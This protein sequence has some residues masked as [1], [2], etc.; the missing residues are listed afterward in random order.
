MAGVDHSEAI[1]SHT[2][3]QGLKFSGNLA[4]KPVN[5]ILEAYKVGLRGNCGAATCDGAG[6]VRKH[7]GTL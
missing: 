7:P 1:T 5:G 6:V 4:L 3:G 2:W